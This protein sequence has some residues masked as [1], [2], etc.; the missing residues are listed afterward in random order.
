MDED[1]ESLTSGTPLSV[2]ITF[3]LATSLQTAPRCPLAKPASSIHGNLA[4]LPPARVLFGPCPSLFQGS[5]AHWRRGSRD[6][7]FHK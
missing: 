7:T 6:E 2:F 4:V 1:A 3:S 5:P